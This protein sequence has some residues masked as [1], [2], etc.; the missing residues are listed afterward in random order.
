MAVRLLAGSCVSSTCL[1]GWRLLSAAKGFCQQLHPTIVWTL[2]V[3]CS[4]VTLVILRPSYRVQGQK[5]IVLGGV[6]TWNLCLWWMHCA[7]QGCVLEVVQVPGWLY[8]HT[9][10]GAS[11]CTLFCTPAHIVIVLTHACCT[12]QCALVPHCALMYC[13]A[14]SQ[15]AATCRL[16]DEQSRCK[17]L[18]GTFN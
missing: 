15:S 5:L 18:P 4:T 17:A 1:F 13:C 14:P 9:V 8:W 2:A 3:L 7:K 16:L 12:V 6:Y 10:C 11:I